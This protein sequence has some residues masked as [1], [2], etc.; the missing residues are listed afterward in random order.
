[1]NGLQRLKAHR[2]DVQHAWLATILRHSLRAG[3][4]AS[5]SATRNSYFK[6]TSGMMTDGLK[7][8]L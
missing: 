4:L 7:M 8:T 1:M 5:Y 2:G 3:V 6:S